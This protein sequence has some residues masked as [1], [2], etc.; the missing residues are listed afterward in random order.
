VSYDSVMRCVFGDFFSRKMVRDNVL[1]AIGT[2]E[3][4]D[5]CCE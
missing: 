1:K 3:V 4:F 2:D 5:D